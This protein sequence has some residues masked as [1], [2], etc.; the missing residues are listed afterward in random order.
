MVITNSK[1][2]LALTLAIVSCFLPLGII[3]AVIAL[4]ISKESMKEI[5]KFNQKGKGFARSA[6]IISIVSVCIQLIALIIVISAIGFNL[7]NK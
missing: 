2:K 6:R 3:L 5:E 4:F 7:F 1:S